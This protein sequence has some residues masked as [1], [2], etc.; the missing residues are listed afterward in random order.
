M[1]GISVD[2]NFD[3]V[4]QALLKY[5]EEIDR[6]LEYMVRSFAYQVTLTAIQ[7][8]P[9]G[10][11]E[12]FLGLYQRR[13]RLF[14]LKPEEGFAKG[15]W[16]L[17]TDGNF[18]TQALYGTGSGSTAAGI[19]KTSIGS[20]KLGQTFYIGTQGFYIDALESGSSDQALDGI[21]APT[22]QHIMNVLQADLVRLFNEG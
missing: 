2:A 15:S 21:K 12:K 8:T 3:E 10:D 13:E 4:Y 20:Y 14:G 5:K 1:I 17:D 6:K 16:Q 22:E 11:S 19:A 18:S 7:N 9:I